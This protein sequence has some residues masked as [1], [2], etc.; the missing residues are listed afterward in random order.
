MNCYFFISLAI[1]LLWL[2][3]SEA[4]LGQN[5]Q[6]PNQNL[7]R[8]FKLSNRCTLEDQEEIR[9]CERDN[10]EDWDVRDVDYVSFVHV[11]L[12]SLLICLSFLNRTQTIADFV[13]SF[14]R[15]YRVRFV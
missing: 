13:V 1:I 12:L 10:L 11:Y 9:K 3:K 7:Q 4:A 2:G 15:H 14:G 8:T 6:P 5:R